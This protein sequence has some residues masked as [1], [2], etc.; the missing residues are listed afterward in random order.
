[1]A[2]WEYADRG[3]GEFPRDA[4]LIEQRRRTGA[5]LYDE[6]WQGEYHITPALHGSHDARS[7]DHDRDRGASGAEG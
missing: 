3:T 7:A 5:D 1:M 2:Q 6:M 4:D